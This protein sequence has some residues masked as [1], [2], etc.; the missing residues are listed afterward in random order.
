MNAVP[1]HQSGAVATSQHEVLVRREPILR[2]TPV[3]VHRP[4]H[5]A[6]EV[7]TVRLAIPPSLLQTAG[8][9]G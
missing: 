9:S 7:Q 3:M 8:P 1:V 6:R 5:T 4:S 2:Q